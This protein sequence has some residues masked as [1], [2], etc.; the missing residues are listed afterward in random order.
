MNNKKSIILSVILVL[1][2]SLSSA[3]HIFSETTLV[4][5][6]GLPLTLSQITSE[7]IESGEF[8]E[9]TERGL[10]ELEKYYFG[11]DLF[12]IAE[13]SYRVCVSED[14]PDEITIIKVDLDLDPQT[15][16][17][18]IF[19]LRTF[20]EEWVDNKTEMWQN[21]SPSQMYKL[22]NFVI[23]T[24]DGYMALFICDD[25]AKALEVFNRL[26]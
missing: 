15:R 6:D 10:D 19:N 24:R 17:Q 2:L 16:T 7:I 8:P 23:D 22:E 4:P 11:I 5:V 12:G 1:V 9:M 14:Y 3:C 20:F 25:S 26:K 21:Y 13:V 18:V